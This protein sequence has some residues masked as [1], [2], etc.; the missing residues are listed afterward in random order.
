MSRSSSSQVFGDTA[1]RGKVRDGEEEEDE[2]D[3]EGLTA[4]DALLRACQR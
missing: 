4:V 1:V 2:R 3:S